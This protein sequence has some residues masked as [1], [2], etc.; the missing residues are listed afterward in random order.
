MGKN[1]IH[2]RMVWGKKTNGETRN[3]IEGLKM[4][5][6]LAPIVK[7]LRNEMKPNNGWTSCEQEANRKREGANLPRDDFC[8]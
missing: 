6:K 8:S 5:K 3:R 4:E 2:W 7:L 1:P